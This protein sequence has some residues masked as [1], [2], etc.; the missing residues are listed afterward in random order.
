M[1]F[2]SGLRMAVAICALAVAAISHADA[3]QTTLKIGAPAPPLQPM[4]WLK[5]EPIS[6]F[7]PGR[8]YVVEFWATWCVPCKEQMP[9][10]S[11]LQ[12]SHAQRLTIV[13][14]NVREAER[15]KALADAVRKF[16]D[17]Q[18]ERMGYTVAMDDPD[19]KTVFNTWM[20][21]AGAYGLPTSFVVDGKGRVVWVGHPVG[22]RESA[23]DT[24]VEQ[25]LAGRSD[26]AAGREA[27]QEANQETA[28]RLGKQSAR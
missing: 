6:K 28:A 24:A 13:G 25:A 20:T 26:L 3:L 23:F 2:M 7:E 10:L 14:V 12:R 16:V 9:H 11:A 22:A 4:S 21:A 19:K 1:K 15:G 17:K 18:G 8:V 5:G 27:Q